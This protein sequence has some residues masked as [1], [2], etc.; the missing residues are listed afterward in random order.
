MGV[1]ASFAPSAARGPRKLRPGMNSPAME[2]RP[3]TICD[4]SIVATMCAAAC[5]AL[6]PGIRPPISAFAAS[7]AC[8]AFR[9]RVELAGGV[10]PVERV[11]H[12]VDAADD[13]PAGAV[14]VR[15]E[16]AEVVDG[17]AMIDDREASAFA[18]FVIASAIATRTFPP[19]FSSNVTSDVNGLISG[20]RDTRSFAMA[21]AMRRTP[22]RCQAV[23]ASG[24]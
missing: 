13:V 20:V 5:M 15:H 18:I 8:V 4:T 14:D 19:I 21:T 11:G 17:V 6:N 9:V 24:R 3:A 22:S 2:V 1:V 10:G 12:V 16:P 23:A 7:M